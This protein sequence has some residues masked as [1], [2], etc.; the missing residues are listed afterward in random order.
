MYNNQTVCLCLCLCSSKIKFIKN[1]DNVYI[2][3]NTIYSIIYKISCNIQYS[4]ILLHN[5]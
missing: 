1:K 3:N 2:I 4:L 5:L